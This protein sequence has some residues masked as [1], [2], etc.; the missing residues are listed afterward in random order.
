MIIL[1]TNVI[2]ALMRRDAPIV[3]WLDTQ[4][5]QSVWTSSV[6]VY[7]TRF[8]IEILAVGRRRRDLERTFE[9]FLREDI[10]GRVLP[11]DT[12]AAESAGRVA[13]ERRRT[14]RTIEIRDV[15]IAGIVI[16]RKATL[17]TG[18]VRHFAGIRL[19]LIDPW[20]R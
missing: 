20:S 14:G 12:P 19:S 6:S 2:A 18:N 15:Q 10:G 16:A 17:A 7:E 5:R 3:D 8:G 9:G 13:A 4:P 11:F 1:D